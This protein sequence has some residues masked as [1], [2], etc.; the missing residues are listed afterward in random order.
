MKPIVVVAGL[1]LLGLAIAE[2][3]VAAGTEVRA[4]ASPPEALR[5][6]HEL[7]RAGVRVTTGSARSSGALLAAG[8]ESASVLVVATDD[9]GEN[10]DAALAARR[11]RKD[12]PLVVRLFDPTLGAYLRA[13]LD[14]IVILSMSGIAA[15]VFAELAVRALTERE[16]TDGTQPP[17]PGTGGTRR[18]RALRMDPVLLRTLVGFA[19][20][21]A[22]SSAYF[23]YALDLRM[24]DALY[25]VWT[26]MTTV[27]YGDI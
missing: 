16:R 10:V 8:L 1:E 3:L 15:P 12:L 14:R 7:E 2:R 17:S 5:Y 19:V 26:T 18:R 25:F 21:V 22:A 11:L 24:L 9:D 27:G 13:T 20:L 6:A 23:A 4:I